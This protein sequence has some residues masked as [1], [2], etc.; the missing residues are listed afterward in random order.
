MES[1]TS[2]LEPAVKRR[3]LWRLWPLYAVV[4]L[5][6][7]LYL[8]TGS[9]GG[10]AQFNPHT[11]Q[12]RGQ[13]EITVLFGTIPIYRSGYSEYSY[14]QQPLLQEL[15]TRGLVAPEEK[16]DRWDW[17]FHWN[18]AWK[19]G[20]GV[21]YD[22]LVRNDQE[23]LD[24]TRANPAMASIFWSEVFRCMRSEHEVDRL[25]GH[26]LL[27]MGWRGGNEVT[28]RKLIYELREGALL[29]AREYGTPAE[30]KYAEAEYR[31]LLS[32]QRPQ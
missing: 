29:E 7:L 11:L 18:D 2:T 4:G 1:E 6:A 5:F 15:V 22:P 25:I 17:I 14:R 19:D 32:Q 27:R 28:L 9:R 10:I 20:Y 26:D 21:W 3:W 23:L 8:F 24:W 13:S 31:K 12:R 16:L 30:R